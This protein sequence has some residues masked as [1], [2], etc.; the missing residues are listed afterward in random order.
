MNW[1]KENWFKLG[2]LVVVLVIVG[3]AYKSFGEYQLM[4]TQQAKDRANQEQYIQEK[5][6]VCLENADYEASLEWDRD[7]IVAGL[8][9][10]CRLPISI[11][12]EDDRVRESIRQD[13]FKQFPQK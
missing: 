10:G 11:T 6:R 7:C 9:K 12:Q 4:V 5:L 13:C 3:V 8:F 1:L 2:F